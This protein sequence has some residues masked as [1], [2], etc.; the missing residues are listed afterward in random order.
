MNTPV[1]IIPTLQRAARYVAQ[2]PPA[3]SG[4]RGHDRTFHVAAV[5]VHGFA[6][7]E[8]DALNMLRKWNQACVPPWSEA[9]LMHKI[10]SAACTQHS[11]P[12]GY[13][14]ALGKMPS[15]AFPLSSNWRASS[16]RKPV[17]RPMVLKRIAANVAVA[18]IFATVS[19]VSAITVEGQDCTS[20]LRSLYGNR[21]GE[22]I[23]I[24]SNMQSQGQFLWEASRC[25]LIRNSQLP[26][27]PSGVWFLPQP[28]DGRFYPN[29]RLGGKMSRRSEESVTAWRFVV[30]EGDEADAED[31]LRCL[32]QMPL[33]ISC[34]CESG[35]RSIHALVQIDAASKKDWDSMVSKM[36]PALV[37]LGADP[38]ALS[39]VR[40]TRLPQAL[41]GNHVQRLIYLD[42]APS[43]QPILSYLQSNSL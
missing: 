38:G 28:V 20:I 24:F 13:L 11:Q 36:K 3:I 32:V 33:P 15:P 18:D 1:Q 30:L 2:C 19:G 41:R 10:K 42:P 17:F 26:C 43:A 5:L 27:G 37:T 14:L 31:R 22:K 9:E 12:R 23:L 7:P 34:I 29:P 21:P 39:S 40:L 4:E 25:A 16:A 8:T 35:G 6:L